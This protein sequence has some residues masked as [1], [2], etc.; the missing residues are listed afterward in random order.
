MSWV[1]RL[2]RDGDR[3]TFTVGHFAPYP[4]GSQ[5]WEP[6]QDFKDEGA[7]R[8]LVH[9]LNGGREGEQWPA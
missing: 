8:A 6:V 7:A 5:R 9:Y 4:D 2:I 1:Y 3:L